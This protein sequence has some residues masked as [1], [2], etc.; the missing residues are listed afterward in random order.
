MGLKDFFRAICCCGAYNKTKEKEPLLRNN[1]S[2][3]TY[4]AESVALRDD[5]WN[6]WGTPH[7]S[8]HIESDDDR[9]LYSLIVTRNQL[10]HNTEEWEK[11]NYDIHTLRQ[12]HREVRG[13][14]RKILEKLGFQKEVD[15]LLLVSKSSTLS[16]PENLSEVNEVLLKLSEETSLFPNGFGVQER[17]LFVLDRLVSLDAA[18]EFFKMAKK[19]YPKNSE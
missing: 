8:S 5:E 4:S 7:D 10:Q 1:H 15:S 18:E 16:D 2:G 6:L 12:T 19:I 11:L 14:W 9:E 17:Y 13:R 3:T